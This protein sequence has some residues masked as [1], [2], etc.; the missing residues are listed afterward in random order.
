[1]VV[2]ESVTGAQ[3]FGQLPLEPPLASSLVEMNWG[4]VTQP[5]AASVQ[6]AELRFMDIETAS[7]GRG[8][9]RENIILLLP[10]LPFDGKAG[11][12]PK[13]ALPWLV[14]QDK[15]FVQTSPRK[16]SA[17]RRWRR[18]RRQSRDNPLQL[19]IDFLVLATGYSLGIIGPKTIGD[20]NRERVRVKGF[21]V[22]GKGRKAHRRAIR[23]KRH[24]SLVK[25]C[26]VASDAGDAFSSYRLLMNYDGGYNRKRVRVKDFGVA[27]KGR[28]AHRRAFREKR[29]ASFVES[30]LTASGAGDAFSSYRHRT[31]LLNYDGDR[32]EDRQSE[33]VQSA[34]RRD[35]DIGEEMVISEEQNDEN[36]WSWV[37][38][39]KDGDPL[40]ESVS[41]LHTT[42][43]VLASE[44]QKLSELGKELEAEE[45]TSGNKDQ[46]VIVLP[47]A[48]VGM[49]ELN[50]KMEH[51]E[52]KLKEASN[53]IREK[54]LRLSKLQVLISTA[55]R[56]TLE[57]EEAA[58]IDQLV[59][60]L[61]D[62]LQEKLEAE[63]QCLVMMEARQNWQVRTEDRA[64]LEEH[65]ASA[66]DNSSSSARMLRKLRET[67]SKIVTLK[68]QVDRLEVHEK[69]LYRA[70]EALRMQSRTF[71]VSLFGLVQ[72]IMLCLSLKVFFAWV[73]APFDEVVPT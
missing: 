49:L 39:D 3:D 20:C 31:M 52:Q 12:V 15:C 22:A 58:S 69:E 62:H 45:S 7:L 42:Q 30:Y 13:L 57:E 70:T 2:L 53:T 5:G 61:E 37:N 10:E 24:G 68:E 66:G 23:G 56:P 25:S 35:S 26:L 6:L 48:H 28:K 73:P 55:D 33:E 34:Y 11:L 51:L 50:E 21:G 41:S 29:H 43:Q 59:T 67:E 60:E 71:K 17:L 44:I 36:E 14:S 19:N 63:I 1:M 64:A 16:C 38:Q 27:G 4:K 8:V 65:R 72:L 46:D 54:D 47:Y 18:V 40:A 9:G 32:S